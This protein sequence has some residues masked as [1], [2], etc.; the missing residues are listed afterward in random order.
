MSAK[1]LFAAMAVVSSAAVLSACQS[2]PSGEA[3]DLSAF[4]AHMPK[5]ILVLPPINDSNDVRATGGFWSTVTYPVAE[6]GYYVVPVTLV[7]ETFRENGV[8]T[9]TD[10]HQIAPSKLKEIFGADAA[11]Y[12]RIKEYGSKYQVV[13][14]TTTVEAEAK[15][16][17]LATG[18]ELW[19]G[20]ERRAISADSG[21][22]GLIGMLVSAALNQISNHL[23]DS[24][25]KVSAV[26]SDQLFSAES[27]K[28]LLHGPRSPQF[29]AAQ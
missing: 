23:Q 13:S 7:N 19:S 28:G 22:A 6:A 14:S 20:S 27:S 9:A 21:N 17:D 8:T 18:Q 11:L 15:L 5:S 12:I 26:V 16:V 24:G 25:H 3:R 2:M 4:R 29:Q 10:S 1:R